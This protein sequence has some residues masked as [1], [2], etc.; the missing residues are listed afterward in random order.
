MTFPTFLLSILT[1]DR[2]D[3]IQHDSLRNQYLVQA[4]SLLDFRKNL[5][6]YP[7]RSL[8]NVAVFAT[9]LLGIGETQAT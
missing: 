2:E 6:M 7:L 4:S 9:T 3:S 8:L 5:R 1:A